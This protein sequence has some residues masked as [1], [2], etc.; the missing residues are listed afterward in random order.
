MISP[1]PRIR[2]LAAGCAALLLANVASA[3]TIPF[4]ST[5]NRLD[6]QTQDCTENCTSPPGPPSR[7]YDFG[8]AIGLSGDSALAGIPNQSRVAVFTLNAAQT[9]QRQTTLEALDR[10]AGDRFGRSIAYQGRKALIGSNGAAYLFRQSNV[11]WTQLG[12]LQAPAGQPVGDFGVDVSYSNLTA[13]VGAP[14][15]GAAGSVYVFETNGEGEVLETTRLT[16]PDSFADDQFGRHV[17]I[18]GD[19]LVASGKSSAS[20]NP[21]VVHIFERVNGGWD[22]VQTLSKNS[23]DLGI[24]FGE[25][26][27]VTDSAIFVG[28]PRPDGEMIPFGGSLYAFNRSSSGDYVFAQTVGPVT[29]PHEIVPYGFGH[30]VA[31]SATQVAVSS[32]R[33]SQVGGD[34]VVVTYVYDR[35]PGGLAPNGRAFLIGQSA[36]LA[37]SGTTLIAGLVQQ[38][39]GP[40]GGDGRAMLLSAAGN[41]AC[42]RATSITIDGSAADWAGVPS[43]PLS[44]VSDSAKFRVQW[45]KDNLY[46]IVEVIDSKLRGDSPTV[47]ENDGVELYL[48][49]GHEGSLP[50]DADDYQ[51]TVDWHGNRGGLGAPITYASAVAITATGYTVEYS[52]PWSALGSHAVQAGRVIGLDI[53]VNDNDHD[54]NQRDSQAIWH[55]DGTGWYDASQFATYTLG[56]DACG[57]GI[58]VTACTRSQTIGIDGNAADWV[59]VPQHVLQATVAG[60]PAGAADS[61]ASFRMQWDS[62]YLFALVEVNDDIAGTTS[63]TVYLNDGVELYLDGLRERSTSYD[64]NDFQLTVDRLGVHGGIDGGL[65]YSSAVSSGPN[66]YTVEYRIP[67]SGLGLTPAAFDVLGLDVAVNDSDNSNGDRDSQIIWNGNGEGWYDTSTFD[68]LKLDSATC[69]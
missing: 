48:D 2:S 34:N 26:V 9:W 57:G 17:S 28:S 40:E 31:A 27:T 63:P 47:Y 54:F 39:G 66:G 1:L 43:H 62:Q 68:G 24:H 45:D 3:Q 69:P 4:L 22:W 60:R 50:Y 12:K 59:G 52:V 11:Q 51:L 13:A 25:A 32:T 55:G 58:G 23:S 38:Q 8:S 5:N 67:W 42:A 35:T 33:G 36:P 15:T 65:T 16:A 30:S 14:A 56:A 44:G 41:N 29:G 6:P 20:G 49:G 53:A 10:V 21:A 61:S 64:S 7:L 19:V 18:D 46:V 37:L